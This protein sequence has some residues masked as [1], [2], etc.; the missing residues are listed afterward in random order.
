MFTNNLEGARRV[1]NSKYTRNNSDVLVNL[2]E[3]NGKFASYF[4]I[5]DIFY[6]KKLQICKRWNA[7]IYENCIQ[8]VRLQRVPHIVAK[9]FNQE[10]VELIDY[11]SIR[12]LQEN[13]RG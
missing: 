2:W 8:S 10:T 12:K 7:Y 5:L 13:E 4:M 11:S 9:L 1:K 6:I 3:S